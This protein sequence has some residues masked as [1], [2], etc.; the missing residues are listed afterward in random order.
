MLDI[1]YTL[2]RNGANE[3]ASRNLRDAS[4]QEEGGPCYPT[5][6]CGFPGKTQMDQWVEMPR[7]V[8]DVSGNDELIFAQLFFQKSLG[9]KWRL[10]QMRITQNQ[11]LGRGRQLLLRII[12]TL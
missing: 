11:I 12:K 7:H 2:D 1:L 6:L 3:F 5:R 10:T 4:H 9:G 8:A